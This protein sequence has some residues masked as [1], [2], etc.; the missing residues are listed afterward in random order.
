MD[1]PILIVASNQDEALIGSIRDGFEA[2]LGTKLD[3]EIVENEKI[4]GGFI[5]IIDGRVYDASFSSRLNELGRR[6]IE[7]DES[8][9]ETESTFST[10]GSML[11]QRAESTDASPLVYEYGVVQS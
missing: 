6:I 2:K 1:R 7:T 4:T 10:V 11:K 8:E 5:A 3:F 9:S